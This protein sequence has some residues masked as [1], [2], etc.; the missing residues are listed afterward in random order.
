LKTAWIVQEALTARVEGARGQLSD[1]E[2][3]PVLLAMF[4]IFSGSV[5]VFV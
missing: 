3:A 1:S 4:V 5:P 2:N